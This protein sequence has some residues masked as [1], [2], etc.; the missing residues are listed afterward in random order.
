MKK[1]KFGNFIKNI[2]MVLL[3]VLIFSGQTVAFARSGG[4]G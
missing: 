2:L 3:I 1:I 4:G